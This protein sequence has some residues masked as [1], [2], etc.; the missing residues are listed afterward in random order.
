MTSQGA[1]YY[2]KRVLRT[3]CFVALFFAALTPGFGQPKPT[4]TPL[5]PRPLPS[6]P[7]I[8]QPP[9]PAAPP[10]S[11]DQAP[12]AIPPA[13]TNNRPPPSVPGSTPLPDR[14]VT[15]QY[16]NSDVVDVL[17]LYE[18]LTGKKLI[19]DNFVQGKVNI[20]L[21][22]PVPREEA[23]KIIE[24]N[25][26]MNGYSLVPAEGRHRQSDRDQQQPAQ[27]RHRDHFR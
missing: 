17:H 19:M 21:S 23:V 5:A 14:T 22:R 18:T 2:I 7:Q 3:I 16:P 4:A 24:I 10:T 1:N 12:T 27:R 8:V 11:G 25:L 13:Q 15:L 9:A 26:L 20:F 6:A